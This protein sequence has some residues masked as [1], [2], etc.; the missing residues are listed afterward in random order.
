MKF[1]YVRVSTTDQRLDSQT[2]A[3][4]ADGVEEKNI[5]T[6]VMTGYQSR[7]KR[8]GLTQMLR[9]LRSGDVVVVFKLDHFARSLIELLELIEDLRKIGVGFKS[10]TEGMDTTTPIGNLLL[11]F[12][13]SLAQFERDMIVERTRAGIAS[14]RQR[15]QKFGR[16]PVMDDGRLRQ[17]AVLMKS[18]KSRSYTARMVGVAPTTIYNYKDAIMAVMATLPDELEMDVT[19]KQD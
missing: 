11:H 16:T 6:D 15:G 7:Q 19:P 18:G 5:F 8:P 12:L 4:K 1:G 3:L 14:A 13:G 9:T 17:A 2:D 10:L